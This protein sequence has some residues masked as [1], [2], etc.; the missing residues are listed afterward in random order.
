[1][2]KVLLLVDDTLTIRAFEK[3]AL[4][5]AYDFIEASNGQM[6]VEMASTKKPDCILLDVTMP[7]MDGLEALKLLKSQEE[8]KKIPVIMVTTRSEDEMRTQCRALGADSFVTKPVERDELRAR[9]REA[10]GQTE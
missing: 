9:V 10:L 1:M 4:G 5:S 6:A 2:K 3:I 7:V 8:T